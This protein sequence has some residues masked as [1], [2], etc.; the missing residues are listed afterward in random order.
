MTTTSMSSNSTIACPTR[1]RRLELHLW[2]GLRAA[3][4]KCIGSPGLFWKVLFNLG[5]I[6]GFLNSLYSVAS[7]EQK[8][9][10]QIQSSSSRPTGKGAGPISSLAVP[11]EATLLSLYREKKYHE[12]I[13]LTELTSDLLKGK[14]LKSLALSLRH[15]KQNTEMIRIL[16]VHEGANHLDLSLM[17][18]LSEAQLTEKIDIEEAIYRLKGILKKHPK[19]TPAWTTLSQFYRDAKNNYELKMIYEDQFKIFGPISRV[20]DTLC[21][22]YSQEGF[23]ENAVGACTQAIEKNNANPKTHLALGNSIIDR[24]DLESGKT[25][26]L[27]AAQQFTK[28]VD[29]QRRAGQISLD[30]KNYAGGVRF[31]QQCAQA[32]PKSDVCLLGLAK[33]FFELANFD[34]SYKA[35][36]DA[37]VVN[38]NDLQDFKTAQRLLIRDKKMT[39][40]NQFETGIGTCQIESERQSRAIASEKTVTK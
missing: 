9:D 7:V 15:T 11:K 39:I 20:L 10:H 2:N 16:K 37:C 21:V 40:A 23:I 5:I 18:L 1:W 38:P 14:S 25:I 27:R 26:I 35:Y 30:D 28:D 13:K 8:E 24:G 6:L 22:I 32:D 31:F 17:T 4:S 34:K 12:I 3:I 33:S 19:Y 36:F 29:L